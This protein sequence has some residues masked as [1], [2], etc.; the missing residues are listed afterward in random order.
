MGPSD[1]RIETD[2][3]VPD[4]EWKRA[5]KK[6]EWVGGETVDYAIGQAMLKCTPLQMCNVA[7]AI[8]NGGTLYRPQLVQKVTSFKEPLRPK[9]VRQLTPDP[10]KHVQV[11][12]ATLAKIVEGM[13]RVMG[14]SGTASHSTIPG[15]EMAGKTGTAQMRKDGRM[16]NN[17]WFIGFAPLEKPKIAVCVFVETGGHGGETAAPIASKMIATYLHAKADAQGDSS[18][19]D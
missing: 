9:V 19:T 3:L 8:G 1:L 6:G 10:L 4:P 13:R 18:S 16:V 2:G 14:P 5:H 15:I 17:A 7:A 12:S 11:S